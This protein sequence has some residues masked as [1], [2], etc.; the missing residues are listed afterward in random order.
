MQFVPYRYVL[1]SGFIFL[2]EKKV[3]PVAICTLQV[4]FAIGFFIS[5]KK[6]RLKVAIS[7]QSRITA[8]RRIGLRLGDECDFLFYGESDEP[9]CKNKK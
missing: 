3:R 6:K 2:L 7:C 4:C 8:W 9:N 5:F 1:Q